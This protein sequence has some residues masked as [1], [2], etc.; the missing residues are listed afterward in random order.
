MQELEGPRCPKPEAMGIAS[1][2]FHVG[3]AKNGRRFGDGVYLAEDL[4][5]SLAYCDKGDLDSNRRQGHNEAFWDDAF[6]IPRAQWFLNFLT[7]FPTEIAKLA[8]GTRFYV[9]FCAI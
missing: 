9:R 2:G 4:A 6:G 7:I 5:K 3:H 1:D 8:G